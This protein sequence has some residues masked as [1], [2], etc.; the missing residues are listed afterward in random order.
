MFSNVIAIKLISNS[1][2]INYIL[3]NFLLKYYKE[4]YKTN[5]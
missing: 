2:L 5:K 4:M 1:I 3:I